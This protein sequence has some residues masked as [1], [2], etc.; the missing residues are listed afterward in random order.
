MG[1]MIV[2]S[3]GPQSPGRTAQPF[4]PSA[5]ACVCRGGGLVWARW[6]SFHLSIQASMCLLLIAFASLFLSEVFGERSGDEHRHVGEALVA[7]PVALASAFENHNENEA[8]A[9]KD[10]ISN[11]KAF[12]EQSDGPMAKVLDALEESHKTAHKTSAMWAR[13][14]AAMNQAYRG[15]Y[16]ATEGGAECADSR[17]NQCERP[18]QKSGSP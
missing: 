10:A 9:S 13:N 15:V 16:K 3:A 7:R 14:A 11:I 2:M 17:C 8:K 4:R 18:S 12:Y 1:F 5:R 6:S